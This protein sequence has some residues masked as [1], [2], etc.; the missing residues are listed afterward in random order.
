MKKDKGKRSAN[1]NETLSLKTKLGFGVGDI[2]G[3][4]ALVIIGFYYLYFLTDVLLIPPALAG[5]AFLVSKSWDAVSDPLMGYLSD[6][7]RTRFGRRRPYFLAGIILIFFS[8]FLL[9]YPIDLEQVSHRFVYVLVTYLVFSTV[10][11]LVMVPYNALASELTLDYN[12]RTS[13]TSFRIFF[14]SVSSLMCAVVPWEIVKVFPDVNMG[15][16]VMGISFGLFFALPFLAVFFAT[17]EREEFQQQTNSLKVYRAFFEPFKTSTF[18]NVLFMYLFAFV[19]MDVLMAVVIYFMTYYLERGSETNFVL[20]TLLVFQI[21]ALPLFAKLSG[22]TDKRTS[23]L[24]A[25]IFLPIVM[26]FGFFIRPGMP[27]PIIYIFAAL[28]GTGTGGIVIMIYSI[29]PDMPDIDELYS[30][31]RREGMY[32]GMFTF[33]RKASS[34]IAIAAISSAISLAGYVPPVKQTVDGVT[35]MIQQPQTSEFFI[36]LRLVFVLVPSVFL[37]FCL[38]NGYRYRLNGKTH[39]ILTEALQLR[40]SGADSASYAELQSNL[41]NIFE[42]KTDDE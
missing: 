8:F 14:S 30:G 27:D 1:S 24:V 7:T 26:L 25:T 2:Y 40:R 38:Y 3:G 17:R 42:R 33:L 37:L 19:A 16:I 34:A 32:S 39:K 21:I 36:I 5:V 31:E 9:W 22:K 13:L 15:F 4:G 41:R 10:I 23:Y 20:G 12:E 18:V 35:Q 29:F 6:R 11:T 28:L